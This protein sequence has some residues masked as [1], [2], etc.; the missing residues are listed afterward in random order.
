MR[1]YGGQRRSQR[2]CLTVEWQ[3]LLHLLTA[4]LSLDVEVAT[5]HFDQDVSSAA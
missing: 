4:M 3:R 2:R 5:R 1:R